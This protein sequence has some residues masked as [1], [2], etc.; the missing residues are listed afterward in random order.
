MS[1][2]IIYVRVSTEKETQDTSIYRQKTELLALAEN[3][4]FNI[5]EII[6]ERASGYEIDRDGIIKLLQMIK[7]EDVDVVLIQDE[8][9]LGRG[10]A[11]IAIISC[12]LK[13]SV[14]IYT[15]SHHGELQLSESDSM[16][17]EIV[18]IVEEFQ[19]K[20]HNAKIKRGMKQAVEN[21]YR[22][23]KNLLNTH[24]ASGRIR[25]EVPILEII[26][27]REKKLTFSEIAS[28]LRGFGHDIS[29]ATVH[30][31]YNEHMNKKEN[32]T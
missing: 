31:R 10:N 7:K 2:A 26:S 5:I 6:E 11:K 4:N 29:K 18:G 27:L 22:P 24:K 9:R 19:R 32:I 25:K 28:T 14:K 15:I 17:L 21:G 13:E 20:I 16:V 1:N 12:L 23:E 30:R 3:F 8:T